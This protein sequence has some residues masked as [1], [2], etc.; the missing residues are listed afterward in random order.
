MNDKSKPV[1]C[2]ISLDA[3]P[4]TFTAAVV[5]GPTPAG[6]TVEKT[7]NKVPLGQ[8]QSWAKKHTNAQDLIVLEASGN[9]FQVVRS[10]AA[11]ER[12]AL[13]LESCQLGKLKEA[14]AN[15]DKISAVRIAKAYLAGTAKEVWVPDAKTQERRDWFHAHRK[16]NK[17][18]NQARNSLLSYLSD[19]GVRLKKGTPL[20]SGPEAEQ[21][22]RTARE[23]SP[24][25]W[26]VLE[27]LLLQL[28]HAEEQRKHWR[29]LIAQEV[30][31]DPNLLSIVRLCG[32]REMVA[33]ALG[34]LVGDIKR[35]AHP[36]K[37]VK[38]IGL[39]PAFDDSG[40]NQWTGGIRG[41][42][43]KDLRCLLIE[44][45]QAILRCSKTPLACWGKK[46][47]GRKGAINLTVAAIAR[48]LA[49][50]VWY[51]MMGRWTT[52]EEIDKR[53]SQKVGKII[54]QVGTA[55]LKNLG[56]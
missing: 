27:L 26:Q 16:A 21:K 18:V 35:F 2:V 56:K 55:G 19:N 20:A 36:K 29:S 8:L 28:R 3:H 47:L 44:A 10:L 37:L 51:L 15:N 45:A 34:A 32:V 4:D 14:H 33:F 7:F 6:A 22:L 9:S 42:G 49:V 31:T 30:L 11:I 25:Q 41:H 53:L 17:R 12:R 43:R 38:Y 40:E 48:K 50:A 13:V 39:N 46:L 5:R 54:S 52:L 24:R 23:W 1:E